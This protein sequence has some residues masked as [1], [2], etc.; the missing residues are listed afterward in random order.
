M[1]LVNIQPTFDNINGGWSIAGAYST[2]YSTFSSA[3]DTNYAT[4]PGSKGVANV[5]FPVDTSSIPAG[6]TI[7]SVSLV[8]RAS[9]GSGTPPS[10]QTAS[11]TCAMMSKDDP[12][13]Y[14][15]RTIYLT[16]TSPQTFT[17]AN[18]TRHPSGEPWDMEM[19]NDLL[20]QVFCY[21]LVSD[22]VRV[23]EVYFAIYYKT[24]PTMI[25]TAPAGYIT[26]AA[27]TLQWIFSQSD[28]DFQTKAE[29]RIFTAAQQADPSFS[30]D[31]FSPISSGTI[32]GNV[33]S[34]QL[35]SPL[36]SGTFWVYMRGTSEAGAVS[37][38]SG[39]QFTIYSIIPG[40]PGV[41]DPTGNTP[42][43]QGIVSL[44]PDSVNGC[45]V[46]TVQDTS[47]L[48]GR[49]MS[50]VN[51]N[52]LDQSWSTTNCSI[53][54]SSDFTFP[55]DPG[56]IW[57]ITATASG[58]ASVTTH[59][60]N[61]SAISTQLT[62]LGQTLAASTGRSV[63]VDINYYD[64]SYNFISTTTGVA[65]LDT[66]STWT[67]ISVVDTAMPSGAAKATATYTFISCA[68]GEK[69][70]LTH[71]GILYGNSTQWSNGGMASRNLL[72]YWYSNCSG[73]APSGDSWVAGSG[74]TVTTA[75]ATATNGSDGA[76]VNKMTCNTVSPTIALR[77]AGS[78]FTSTSSSTSYTLNKPAGVTSGD[79]M[80]AFVTATN[81][82]QFGVSA[83][84]GWTIVDSAS[85]P[86]SNGT[87]NIFMMV[88]K[89]TAGTSEPSTWSG[90]LVSASSRISA[91]VVAY[92]GAASISS[93]F[94]A[95][96]QTATNIAGTVFT[97]P[98][99]FNTDPGAWRIS[100]FAVDTAGSSATMTAN[101]QPPSGVPIQ[102]VGASRWGWQDHSTSFTINK[103][104][105]VVSGDLMIA[106]I[107]ADV[108]AGIAI[109]VP[110]GWTAV[111][112][113]AGGAAWTAAT[114][115]VKRTAGA[116]EPSSWTGSLSAA[117]P[118]GS[119][120]FPKVT[121]C[122]AYR[123]CAPAS[124]Q[125]ISDAA[126]NAAGYPT[127]W[128]P[129]CTNTNANAW[130]VGAFS[131]LNSGANGVNTLSA[132]SGSGISGV[133]QRI[134]ETWND[135]GG[136]D[137]LCAMMS[138]SNHTIPTGTFSSSATAT[139]PTTDAFAWVG[140]LLPATPPT[141]P[142]G[143]TSRLSNTA[144]ISNPWDNLAVFDSN[145]VVSAAPWSVT[146]T[147]S[148]TFQTAT[149]WI[150]IIKPN[151][152]VVNGLVSAKIQSP[153]D[154]S[155]VD[156]RALASAGN[157][158]MAGTTCIGSSAG[159]LLVTVN[160]YRANQLIS[161]QTLP[162]GPFNGSTGNWADCFAQFQMPD[163]T[164]R[165]DVGFSCSGRN[166]GDWI[167]WNRSFLNLGFDPAYVPGTSEGAHPV[168]SHPEIQ[169]SE[170]I[171]DGNGYGD[172]LPV[173]GTTQN[174]PTFGLDKYLRFS[175]HT[176][177]PLRSRRYRMRTVSY[178]LNGDVFASDWGPASEVVTFQAQ[179]W[180]LKDIG[181]STNNIAL[182]VRW[183]DMPITKQNTAVQFQALGEQYPV[184]LT[185]GM[186]SD[187]FPVTL[188]P[189][190]Q[191]EHEQLMELLETG[192]TLYLQSDI[193][194]AWWVQALGDV[195][196]TILATD[197]RK[198]NPLR[199]VDVTFVQ[200]GPVE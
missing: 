54:E 56:Q 168:W 32:Y 23:Y 13:R 45:A 145:G 65:Q 66:S 149:G 44:V 49:H 67:P 9:K 51:I 142:G 130:M 18:Y 1:S 14:Y 52:D 55:G 39:R 10:G 139:V 93:Q 36:P 190:D 87:N 141:P 63:H 6:A 137:V 80:I 16:S 24:A 61:T 172:W 121:C 129:N 25:V 191:G 22:V 122:V 154:I 98:T 138:D 74:T 136:G 47:N 92:S 72:D 189:V 195:K 158:I 150:G 151:T 152:G 28:C 169:Y 143:E 5:G 79:L 119:D 194:Q 3:V 114:M 11:L 106:V 159:T 182:K 12:T 187:T 30:P 127:L 34:Y 103:P 193:D 38:W 186:K 48:L 188:I 173:P 144:G 162:G 160:F 125:F 148:A 198:T 111:R 50:D 170:N 180:W 171:Q 89:R 192:K 2:L 81:T 85:A 77:A 104:A 181:D 62:A 157:A 147:S 199:A 156:D 123:N 118:A 94:I 175:D 58:N 7:Q 91:A 161:S 117:P 82:N 26:T 197:G 140:Y 15:Q 177:I 69:H 37:A 184:V 97:T 196:R 88:L 27:P 86:A 126:T 33:N 146:A 179:S 128:S 174:V 84:S 165:V 164:T 68:A 73:T 178:G 100:A 75:T 115:V 102:F 99:V 135:G 90:S 19:I 43:G 46:L 78:V 185:D 109:N 183:Q 124:S 59:Y 167:E 200:V 105:G 41:T 31:T 8:V 116:S 29:Y 70:Y 133:Q 96:A 110:T 21:N 17:V 120:P 57:K 176:I 64:A 71:A 108:Q 4:C 53:A 20:F 166:I 101:T 163:G 42:S 132:R 134:S 40:V 112:S 153:I 35:R 83:P 131:S 107:T 76:P 113:Y 60:V 95:E 155:S